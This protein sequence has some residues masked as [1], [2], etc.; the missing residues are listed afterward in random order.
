MLPKIIK[1]GTQFNNQGKV[2]SIIRILGQGCFG[3]VYEASAVNTN[4][5][6]AIKCIN[7]TALM[8]YNK[9]AY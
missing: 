7:R 4:T 6:V 2:Y 3:I 9:K 8:N 5:P 1:N